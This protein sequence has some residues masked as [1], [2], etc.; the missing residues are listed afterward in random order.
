MNRDITHRDA[1]TTL[2]VKVV[3]A[4]LAFV[5][6]LAVA[7]KLAPLVGQTVIAAFI[8]IAIDTIVRWMQRRGFGRGRAILTTLLA[9]TVLGMLAALVLIGPAVDAANKL[10]DDGPEIVQGVQEL[11]AWQWL[12][13]NT[14]VEDA[15]LDKAKDVAS[16]LPGDVIALIMSAVGGIFGLVNMLLMIIFLVT[17]GGRVLDLAVRLWPGM[18]SSGPWAV[19]TGAYENIGRY[20]VGA[21]FQA[22]LAGGSLT[23]MLLL[24]GTPYAVPLGFLMFLL[25]YVPL[26]GATLGAIPAV[27][28]ALFAG[29]ITDGL[30]A[31]AF[32]VVY[33]QLENAVIQ[34][35]IQGKVVQLPV[36][37]I[38]FSVMIGAELLGV[39]G[40]LLA[41]PTAS[42]L[43][44]I[45][46]Q[47]IAYT[48][49]EDVHAPRLFDDHGHPIGFAAIPEEAP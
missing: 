42:I 11:E 34:P 6:A 21:T 31:T 8:A 2:L 22:T 35:R 13:Q 18:A 20:L 19:T 29:G 14:S 41:V 23:L 15:L 46:R 37:A 44:I 4:A 1:S 45:I 5:L 12:E 17:G 24:L 16:G 28:A 32:I 3:I 26:V 9:I 30:I 7:L 47:W 25:D 49:R 39:A 40:A 33:Q 36:I 43:S 10:A 27:A 48:G 38:F